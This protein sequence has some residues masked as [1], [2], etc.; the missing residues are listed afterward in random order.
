M[1]TT[2]PAVPSLRSPGRMLQ[3]PPS[4]LLLA[5]SLGLCA[6]YLDLGFLLF[7]KYWWKPDGFRIA[8]DFPWTVP[9]GYAVI[10]LVPGVLL[11]AVNRLW[12]HLIALRTVSWLLVTLAVWSAALR[13]PLYGQCS[14]LLAI[15]LGRVIGDRI[16]MLDWRPRQTRSIF[17]ALIGI[18]GVLAL[19]SSGWQAFRE[20]RAEIGLSPAP[21]LA[22]NVVLIVW[23]TVRA[24]E[25]SLYGYSRETTPNLQ[26]WAR[27]GVTFRLAVAPAP[28]TFPSHSCFFTGE[29]PFRLD[30]QWKSTL[31][32]PYPTLA[33]FLTTRGY[34]TAGFVANT[35][36]AGHE[37]GLNRGFAHYDDHPLTPRSILTRT[38]PGKW[39]LNNL[40]SFNRYYD[41]KW[42]SVQSRGAKAITADFVRWLGRRRTDRPFFAFLN[43][44]DAHDP[45]I[46]SPEHTKNFGIAPTSARD[47]QFLIDYEQSHGEQSARESAMARDCYDDCIASL[48]EDLG[49]LLNRLQAGGILE[50]TDVI[51]TSDHGES[52]GSHGA[53]GHTNTVFL[54]ETAVPLVIISRNAPAGRTVEC[55]VSLRDLPATV[56]DL[57][58]MSAASPFRG[59]SLAAHWQSAP[60]EGPPAVTS[61]AFSE[62]VGDKAFQ[63]Q[64][65]IGRRHSGFQ[66]SVVA[67][68][69][70]YI[71]TGMGVEE[72][73]DLRVDPDEQSN[74]LKAG[75]D[76]DK[77]ALFRKVLLDVLSDEPG[78][79]EVEK[80]YLATY[81]SW[82]EDVVSGLSSQEVAAGD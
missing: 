22:R 47:Y 45:Y 50:D 74:L 63:V 41:K 49:R 18:L 59:R 36:W 64:P 12:P 77:A 67:L 6:G 81:R 52:F 10:M 78:S 11:A 40:L 15:G 1:A 44:L 39:I 68:D 58:G 60:G 62:R 54:E 3:A 46:P 21:R 43:Y 33:E 70:H 4:T 37:T 80:A 14:L 51:I 53:T 31:D 34:Q 42:I 17:A 28:W 20:Y 55:P 48:D 5:I 26:R 69:H 30:S 19:L 7:K 13:A 72:L 16:A 23:D 71:R 32:A 61:P 76:T 8:S 79:S 27:K 29:W 38:V 56:V 24:S 2:A 75:S 82:L 57:L 65:G 66:M 73:Y 35:T 9:V 25:L